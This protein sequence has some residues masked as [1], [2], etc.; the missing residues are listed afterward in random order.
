MDGHLPISYGFL[1]SFEKNY[2]NSRRVA[3]FLPLGRYCSWQCVN[4]PLLQMQHGPST[5]SSFCWTY[6]PAMIPGKTIRSPL[7]IYNRMCKHIKTN[8]SRNKLHVCSS[9]IWIGLTWYFTT[10]VEMWWNCLKFSMILYTLN[11]MYKKL[12]KHF[13]E[14][15]KNRL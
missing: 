6:V 14:F 4:A 1:D 10:S 11:Y 7:S 3:L 9:F 8:L 13:S 5:N 12:W 2:F 15:V